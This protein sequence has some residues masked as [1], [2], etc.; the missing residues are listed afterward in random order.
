M[1]ESV[2]LQIGLDFRMKKIKYGESTILSLHLWDIA[3]EERTGTM[4]SVFYK[5]AVGCFIFFDVATP[6]TLTT[7]AVKWKQDFDSKVITKAG[8]TI[9]CVLIGN[10]VIRNRFSLYLHSRRWTVSV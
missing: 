7:G 2:S 6:L 9:P 10:K 8:R 3:G 5:G 1:R 4:T